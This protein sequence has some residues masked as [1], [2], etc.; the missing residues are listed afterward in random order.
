MAVEISY[1]RRTEEIRAFRYMLPSADFKPDE[2]S[3]ALHGK[4][5]QQADQL[6]KKV[7][8]LYLALLQLR[9]RPKAPLC[10]R[11]VAE[12][13]YPNTAMHRL[14]TLTTVGIAVF[15]QASAKA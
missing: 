3:D 11:T 14:S 10:S 2:R 4:K 9:E 12:M 8:C 15:S 5:Q 6:Q 1:V 13:C 7:R